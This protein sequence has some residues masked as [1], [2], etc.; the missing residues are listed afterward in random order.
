MHSEFAAMTTKNLAKYLN[1][2][3]LDLPVVDMTELTGVYQVSLDIG[4]KAGGQPSSVPGEAPD[5]NPN[6]GSILESLHKLG[7]N[8]VSRN[9]T[10]EKFIVDGVDRVPAEN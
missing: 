1:Q 3:M 2:G 8:L 4:G 9:E 5:P 10:V 7:L 6:A